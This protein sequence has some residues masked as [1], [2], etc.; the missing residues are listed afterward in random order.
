M[1]RSLR[2][3]AAVAGASLLL[4]GPALAAAPPKKVGTTINLQRSSVGA[5]KPNTPVSKVA[6][7]WASP[8]TRTSRATAATPPI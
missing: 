5:L 3:A 6:R 8:T 7:S 1:A 4:A 2:V